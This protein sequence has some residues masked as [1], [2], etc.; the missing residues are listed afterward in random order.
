MKALS[1]GPPQNPLADV[2]L[3]GR[4]TFKIHFPGRMASNRGFEGAHE[5]GTTGYDQTISG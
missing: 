2:R 1:F 3:D 4:D 5:H